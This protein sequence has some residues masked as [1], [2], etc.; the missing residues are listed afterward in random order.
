MHLF[1]NVI[2]RSYRESVVELVS[3]DSGSC[4][5]YLF[6]VRG[7]GRIIATSRNCML[8]CDRGATD[9]FFYLPLDFIHKSVIV[10]P[11]GGEHGLRVIRNMLRKTRQMAQ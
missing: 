7:M 8:L 2:M 11:R 10:L 1:S 9:R 5:S 4:A 6:T 3:K